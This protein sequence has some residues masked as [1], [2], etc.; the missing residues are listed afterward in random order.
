MEPEILPPDQNTASLRDAQACVSATPA[1]TVAPLFTAPISAHD[2]SGIFMN[3]DGLLR[4]GWSIL[5]F[6]GL[7]SVFG[8]VLSL[9]A[10]GFLHHA[11][12][13][14]GSTLSP[15]TMLAGALVEFLALLQAALLVAKIENRSLLE[16]NFAGFSRL[17]HFLSGLAA[18]FAALTLLMLLMASGG[19][20]NFAGVALT[21]GE[22]F[23]YALLWGVIFLL[24]ALSEEGCFRCYLQF[25]LTRGINFW[26]A[27]SALVVICGSLML[28]VH[29][30]E[31]WGVYL[32]ALLGLPPC[33]WLYLRRLQNCSFWY[34]AWVTS[35]LF[36]FIHTSN[37]G[38]SWS[39]IF[40]ASAIGFIFCVSVWLTGSAWWAIGCH[41][42]WDWA[43]TYFYGTADSGLV[44][45]GHFLTTRP[46][47]NPLWSG[48][49]DG[50][51]G[52]LLVFPVLLFLLILVVKLY[53]RGVVE[54]AAPVEEQLS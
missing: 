43:E 21:G 4:S 10:S 32:A 33:L 2:A 37:N 24:V 1:D 5:I 35:T 39:G 28:R 17:P 36:G 14:K 8:I 6:A 38:E 18:G 47:G 25:T 29:G 53:G 46:A 13:G 3:M 54:T 30:N 49:A 52:S 42:A 12:E 11:Q 23:R 34:A 45:T 48:G 50:P 31:A 27:L 15:S 16:F 41:A 20:I 22:V 51:E 44:A 7:T 40:A 26:W 19:W 9:I